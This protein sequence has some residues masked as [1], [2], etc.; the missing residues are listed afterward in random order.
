LFDVL[1]HSVTMFEH[2]AGYKHVEM[3]EI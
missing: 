3:Y 1:E 2:N